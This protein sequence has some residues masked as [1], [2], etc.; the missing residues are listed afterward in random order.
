MKGIKKTNFFTRMSS[1]QPVTQDQ[2]DVMDKVNEGERRISDLER[3][4]SVIEEPNSQEPIPDDLL[5][6]M[7][8]MNQGDR[9]ISNLERGMYH[10]FEVLEINPENVPVTDQDRVV[11][12]I[13]RHFHQSSPDHVQGEP[14]IGVQNVDRAPAVEDRLA[15]SADVQ[16]EG[17]I[18][19][20]EAGNDHVTGS[21]LELEQASAYNAA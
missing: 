15:Q 19:M 4:I 14:A 16:N 21:G 6:V 17:G 11:G 7:D 10:V 12:V 9:R 2:L 20:Q 3:R 8:R 13:E 5:D 1:V 18:P